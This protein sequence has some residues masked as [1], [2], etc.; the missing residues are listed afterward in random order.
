MRG[1][2]VGVQVRLQIHHLL[3][4]VNRVVQP[5]LL[6]Q[7]VAQKTVV[8]AKPSL[9]D[10]P[11]R[12]RFGLFEAMQVLQY[13]P[14]QQHHRFLALRIAFLDAERALLS[15]LVKTR[16]ETFTR[17]GYERPA[18]LF[19]SEFRIPAV[20]NLLLEAANF[21]VGAAVA[22]LRRQHQSQRVTENCGWRGALLR[23][24]LALW[25]V[26]NDR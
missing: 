3:I 23:L 9:L 6:H 17:L 2:R 25:P 13:M 21:P 24:T 18:E 10:Q 20:A 26:G 4:R 16:V 19:E 5:A 8:K 12:Q 15:E 1:T 7:S 14:A 22:C 11:S